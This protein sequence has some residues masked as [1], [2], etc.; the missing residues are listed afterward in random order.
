MSDVKVIEVKQDGFE[1][2]LIVLPVQVV[3]GVIQLGV[4]PF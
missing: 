1:Y 4:V 2:D 3:D